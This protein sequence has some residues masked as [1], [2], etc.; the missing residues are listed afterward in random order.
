MGFTNTIPFTRHTF[1]WKLNY[2]H[3][4]DEDF[5]RI[6]HKYYG[7]KILIGTVDIILIKISI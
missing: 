1:K 2:L 7:T 4:F 6:F 3:I 5:S